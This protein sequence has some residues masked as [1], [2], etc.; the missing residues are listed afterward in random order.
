MKL[1]HYVISEILL[2]KYSFHCM[3]QNMKFMY[4]SRDEVIDTWT[5]SHV[6]CCTSVSACVLTEAVEMVVAHVNCTQQEQHDQE[7]QDD[8]ACHRTAAQGICSQTDR[9][10]GYDII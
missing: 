10:L 3:D 1:F 2:R 6:K 7:H 4:H 8:Y 5:Y 9:I